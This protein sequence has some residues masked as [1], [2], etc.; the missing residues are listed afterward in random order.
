MRQ[1]EEVVLQ[2]IVEKSKAPTRRRISEALT[3]ETNPNGSQ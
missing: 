2:L 1:S 3:G